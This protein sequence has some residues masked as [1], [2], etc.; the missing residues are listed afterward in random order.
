[1]LKKLLLL[2]LIL[3]GILALI[4]GY[5]NEPLPEG[6][7]SMEAEML[8]NKM[9]KAINYSAWDSTV[10]AKWSFPGGHHYLWDKKRK[11]VAVHWDDYKVLL[12]TLDQSGMAFKNDRRLE[13]T[14]ADELQKKAW[15]YFVNDSFWLAAPFKIKDP[16]TTRSIVKTPKGDALL[17]HYSSGGLTPGDKYLWILDE[18]GLPVSWKLWVQIIPVGGLEFS[19]SDWQ[20]YSTGARL[21]S[22]HDGI[23]DIKLS[24]I[25]LAMDVAEL[26]NGVDPFERLE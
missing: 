6:Q 5:Y 17:V 19:W 7:E 10:A 8:A 26:N 2:V 13:A 16:G 3:A 12:N 15:K 25:E 22:F 14:K 23:I 1:M 4:Y 18:N 21:S 9:L 20:T 24:Q 11:Y